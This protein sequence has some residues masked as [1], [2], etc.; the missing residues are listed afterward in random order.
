ME[1]KGYAFLGFAIILVVC[2]VVT[3]KMVTLNG[4]GWTVTNSNRSIS[5]N[6]TVPGGIYS[7]LI[8]AGIIKDY[9][10]YGKNDMNY[11]WVGYENWTY[12]RT[13]KLSENDLIREARLVFHGLDTISGI[14]LNGEVVGVCTNMFVRTVLDVKD[15]LKVGENV[16]EVRF[17]SPILSGRKLADSLGYRVPPTCPSPTY[18]GECNVNQLRKM[19]ASF[20]W[21]WGP[22]FPS[23]GIWKDVQLELKSANV[24][25]NVGF[26][27]LDLDTDVNSYLAELTFWF[28]H[29]RADGRL[30]LNLFLEQ[31]QTVNY[32]TDIFVEDGEFKM[33]LTL[34]KAYVKLWWPRGYGEPT[35]YDLRILFFS[36]GAYQRKNLRIG[37]RTVEMVE[38]PIIYGQEEKGLTFYLA[39]NKVPVFV[40]GANWIPMDVLPERGSCPDRLAHLLDSAVE[41]N[42]NSLRVWGGGVY[43][44]DRFYEYCDARGILIWQDLMFACAMYPT[45]AQF[46]AS[47]ND[48]IT[49]Q[50]KRM[51]Y[52]PSIFAYGGNNENEAALVQNWYGTGDNYEKYKAD[53][54]TLYVSTIKPVVERLDQSRQ[55]FT[56][57]PSNGK[58]TVSQGYVADSPQS[59]FFGDVH[60]YIYVANTWDPSIY[61]VPRFASEYGMQSLPSLHTLSKVMQPE[62]LAWNSDL[63]QWRQHLALGNGYI[64]TQILLNLPWSNKTE[65][66]I[67]LSQINQAM[68]MKTETEHYRRYKT[69]VDDAYQG[70]TM[71]ALYWQLN[72]VWEAPS[73]SSIDYHGNWK[74]IHYFAK[75]FFAD[76]IIVPKKTIDT[77]DVYVVSDAN[78]LTDPSPVDISITTYL[79]KWDSFE[80]K[81]SKV[82]KISLQPGESKLAYSTPLNEIFNGSKMNDFFLTFECEGS[83][84]NFFFPQ[85]LK[86][87]NYPAAEVKIKRA[88]ANGEN[89]AALELQTDAIAL[90]VWLESPMQTRDTKFSENGFHMFYPAK[91]VNITFP[92]GIN[93]QFLESIT[94]RNLKKSY[95]Y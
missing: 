84:G 24:L 79:N 41:A 78:I 52:H 11:R 80:P 3:T 82:D 19:Q 81:G 76:L 34:P 68:A 4:S 92:G 73:W 10:F 54:V 48:E 38:A 74:M 44:S 45:S 7:D 65:D 25:R 23:V 56:S 18:H 8:N 67:Y 91:W 86:N 37:V 36:D 47:V 26:R 29:L 33:N 71:G 64:Q 14:W 93:S 1:S 66:I 20:S 57:S 12:S 28:E 51:Q 77:I 50:I 94:V 35:L 16:L 60:F 87:S 22:A 95:A 69:I 62:D 59:N 72:D 58:V 75:D 89:E 43:E 15:F 27:T 17:K 5:I 9:I 53:Y 61:P 2:D 40:K 46:L 55:Y 88:I 13:F 49:Q 39:V 90:F 83:P 30:S 21:D 32:S 42:F 70:R 85:P 6:A 31:G 63:M